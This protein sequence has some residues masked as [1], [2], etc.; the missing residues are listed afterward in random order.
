MIYEVATLQE[1]TK[2]EL[3]DLIIS[4]EQ[5]IDE[6]E[7]RNERQFNL[8]MQKYKYRW[9]DLR[10]NPDDLPQK[11]GLY[12]VHG[13]WESGKHQEGECE[14]KTYDGYFSASWN[15]SVIAWKEEEP[16]E[17]AEKL[18]YSKKDVCRVLE[19]EPL[20]PPT[21]LEKIVS[22]SDKTK[23]ELLDSFFGKREWNEEVK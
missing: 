16:F 14:Y 9:H 12:W 21:E 17:E 23:Q 1:L 2:T 4:L 15:F 19:S 3:I 13:V 18:N 22:L 7:E 20:L 6:L 5:Y 8:Q 11:D 10:K